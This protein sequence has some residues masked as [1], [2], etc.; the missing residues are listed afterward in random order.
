[1]DFEACLEKFYRGFLSE[2]DICIDVGAHEGRHLFPM[3][4]CIGPAGRALAFEPIPWLAQ[5]LA[6][7]ISEAGYGGRVS[8]NQMALSNTEG[9]TTFMVAED[10]PGYSG[11]LQ[12]QYDVPT[13]VSEI[14]VLLGRLDTFASSLDRLDY[15]KIDAE[16]AEWHI[17][18]GGMSTLARLQPVITFEFGESSYRPYKVDPLEVH[19]ALAGLDYRILDIKGRELTGPEF[20]DSSMRQEVWDYV[21]IP[22]SEGR[23]LD[24]LLGETPSASRHAR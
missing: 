3:I 15:L 21:A 19:A 6:K 4:E 22:A 13:R 2:G 5:A 23:R 12:R 24:V 18:Q 20:R 14:N 10:A 11:I 8:V 9:E 7:K 1:M 17:L 16:G